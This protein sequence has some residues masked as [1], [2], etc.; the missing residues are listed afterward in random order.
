MV[1][2]FLLFAEKEPLR[3]D[4]AYVVA[5]QFHRLRGFF[6]LPPKHP[7][8]IQEPDGSRRWDY[9]PDI[10][11]CLRVTV[12]VATSLDK[13]VRLVDVSHPGA[14]WE[15]V[16][17]LVSAETLLP[18]LVAPDGRRLEGLDSFVPSRVKEF[19]ARG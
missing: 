13:P 5:S 7:A 1:R 17:R 12:S 16:D 10:S 15:L 19:L 3:G 18:L 2:P 8:R 11:E 6:Q 4:E 9:P 14:D